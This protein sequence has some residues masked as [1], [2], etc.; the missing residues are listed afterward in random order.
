VGGGVEENDR[1]NLTKY[2]GNFYGNVTMKSP[3]QFIYANNN[4]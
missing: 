4:V 1:A 2:L 3:E